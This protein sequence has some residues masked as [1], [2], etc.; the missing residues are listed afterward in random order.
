M[1]AAYSIPESI[2]A[3]FRFRSKPVKA[4]VIKAVIPTYKD[5]EGL[6][7][8]LDS[9]L[10]LKTPP[11]KIS[12]ANDNAEPDVPEWLNKY[13]IELIE[14]P[15]NL[16]PA[17]ARNRAF[18]FTQDGRPFQK[19]IGAINAVYDGEKYPRYL[20]SGFCRELK[21]ADYETEP[22]LFSWESEIDWY[23]FT[24]CGC[25]H[26]PDLFLEF[27][28]SWEECGDCCVAISG[29]VTGSGSGEIN[30]YM[31]EQGI[32]NPPIER[33]V[34]GV[35]LPQAIITANALIAGLPFAF[36]GGFDTEF[37][38]AAGEDLDMGIRLRDLGIIAWSPEAKVAHRFE[39]SESDFYK[40]FRRYGRGN[41]KLEVKHGLPSLRARQFVPEKPEH[42]RL[43]DVAT[44]ALQSGYDEA[45]NE[46]DRGVLKIISSPRER[47]RDK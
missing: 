11:K 22:K 12:V 45:I 21:Y 41:R 47:K 37:Q 28:K 40:R 24:D 43:A 9:L 16:G 25:T 8:T 34:H 17:Q 33:T 20:T 4:R 23:Y 32:L 18:G 42:R 27:E 44:Q 36:L 38:E 6:R 35:Y 7:T 2:S 10:N 19:L 5:W 31:T 30:D 29:S 39:E 26:H 15:G 13:P 46:S 3:R 1:T 14:Y